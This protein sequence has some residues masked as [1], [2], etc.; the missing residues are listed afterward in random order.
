MKKFSILKN[1]IFLSVISL[2]LVSVS[3]IQYPND[4][5]NLVFDAPFSNESKN[6]EITLKNHELNDIKNLYSKEILNLIEEVKSAF[7]NYKLKYFRLIRK[8]RSLEN[9]VNNLIPIQEEEHA[10][11]LEEFYN[12]WFNNSSK[13][14]TRLAGLLEKYQLIFNDVDA[15]IGDLNLNIDSQQFLKRIKVIDNRLTGKDINLGQLEENIISSWNFLKSNLFNLDNITKKENIEKINLDADK[16][17]HTHSHAIVN[18]VNE[19]GLWHQFLKEN[20]GSKNQNIIELKKDY[21][22]FKDNV[23]INID[24]LNYEDDFTYI[25]KVFES[26]LEF[27]DKNNLTKQE[28][29]TKAKSYM[30]KIKEIFLNIA[31]KEGLS[32]QSITSALNW[33]TETK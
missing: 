30:D 16:N 5:E 22:E 27:E 23:R 18:L 9:K 11:K 1:F 7:R 2:P 29:Q 4:D 31:K 17:S 8:I 25:I 20:V 21:E 32:N 33:K 10:K 6:I 15:V 28:F 3:C 13:N 12:K 14:K 26:N 24:H 19:M